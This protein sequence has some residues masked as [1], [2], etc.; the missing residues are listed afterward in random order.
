MKIED[1]LKIDV[2]ILKI[3][4]FHNNE[5]LVIVSGEKDSKNVVLIINIQSKKVMNIIG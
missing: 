2:K 3:E 5:R 1:Q 4:T